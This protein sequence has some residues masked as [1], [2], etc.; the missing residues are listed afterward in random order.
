MKSI[1][2]NNIILFL[3][4]LLFLGCSGKLRLNEFDLSNEYQVNGLIYEIDFSLTSINDSISRAN[5]RISPNDL[6]FSKTKSG[7]YIARYTIG[8][9]VFE[10]YNDKEPIDTGTINYSIQEIKKQ[11]LHDVNFY[12]PIG[13]NYIV[14]V[15]LTDDNRNHTTSKIKIHRKKHTNDRSYF[16][17]CSL[18]K[19]SNNCSVYQKD[20][21]SLIP[22]N[23][24]NQAIKVMIFQYK[25]TSAAKPYEVNYS[26]RLATN[27]DSIWIISDKSKYSFPPLKSGY[28]HF[29]TDTQKQEGFSVFSID[30]YF[31][32][33]HSI[34]HANGALG[35]LLD[36]SEYANLLR[37]KNQKKS[38][39]NEW[40]KLAGNRHRA[41]NLIKSYYSEVSKANKLFTNN[42]PGWSTDRGMIYIIYG[43][44]KIVYRYEN[45]ETWIYGEENNLLSEE[46][47]FNK[48]NSNV[49]DHIYELKRNINFK[50]S[51]NR[52]VN[53]WIE[54]RG[55]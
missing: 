41:R 17:I 55:Y 25:I 36:K 50:I 38:F 27:P 30:Q 3:S 15:S 19:E 2:K 49:S 51:F 29:I 28:Y 9:K 48:I 8:Y 23:N 12:A 26:Y 1:W 13:K 14:K 4:T 44:P 39:E 21:F 47:E 11:K 46:F 54:E 34:K 35:Y 7:N 43:P 37:N 42:Q 40:L 33:I 5:I 10:G 52:M 32:K 24:F 53:A 31:P 6:L 22:P 20:S 18:K 16:K 45:S